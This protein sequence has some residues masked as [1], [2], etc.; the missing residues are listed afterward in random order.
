MEAGGSGDL[1]SGDTSEIHFQ[2]GYL[3]NLAFGYIDEALK[4]C[5][6]EAPPLCILQALIV[7]TH[8]QLTQ[9][10]CG[11]VWRSLGTYL[12]DLLKTDSTMYEILSR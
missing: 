6:D 8:Y 11:K 9:G 10:I 7:A 1:S 3:L 12:R 4:E 2:A 5:G